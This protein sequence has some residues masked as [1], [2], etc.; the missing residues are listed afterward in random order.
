MSDLAELGVRVMRFGVQETTKELSELEQQAKKTETATEKLEE[1]TGEVAPTMEDAAQ[2]A[3]LFGSA[4][5]GITGSLDAQ[6]IALGVGAAAFAAF[7]AVAERGLRASA[8]YEIAGAALAQSLEHVG[9]RTGFTIGQLQDFAGEI[10]RATGIAED[11]TLKMMATLNRVGSMTGEEFKKATQLALD[12]AAALGG[13]PVNAAETLARALNQPA[14]G[15]TLLRRQFPELNALTLDHARALAESGQ[16]AKA[17]ALIMD[18]LQ[19]KIGGASGAQQGTLTGAWLASTDATDDFSRTLVDSTGVTDLAKGAL[20]LYTNVLDGATIVVKELT[21]T[22]G[23][24]FSAIGGL[25]GEI[26]ELT[27]VTRALTLAWDALKF[28][29]SGAWMVIKEGV[30]A[31]TDLATAMTFGEGSGEAWRRMALR[32]A[33]AAGVLTGNLAMAA[34]AQRELNEAQNAANGEAERIEKVKN[35]IRG[36][37]DALS[38]VWER[39]RNIGNVVQE[40][41]AKTRQE[42]EVLRMGSEARRIWQAGERAFEQERKK[43]IDA[44]GQWGE[45]E[46]AAANNARKHAEDLARLTI[47]VSKNEQ[48]QRRRG[49]AGDRFEQAQARAMLS[50]REYMDALKLEADAVNESSQ[51]HEIKA[52]IMRAENMLID[53]QGRKLG[54][55]TDA[56]REEIKASIERKNVGRAQG[57]V[58]AY[59]RSLEQEISLIRVDTSEREE[60]AAVMRAQ[61]LLYDEQGNKIAELDPKIEEHIRQLVREGKEIRANEQAIQDAASAFS[62]F[63]DDVISD[64]DNAIEALIR[65]LAKLIEIQLQMELMGNSGGGGLFGGIFESIFGSGGAAG[66]GAGEFFDAGTAVGGFAMKGEILHAARGRRLQRPQ[67]H[68]TRAGDLMTGEQD[69]EAV[70]PLSRDAQGNLGLRGGGSGKTVVQIFDQRKGGE[71]AKTEESNDANGDRMIRVYIRDEVNRAMSDGS[72]DRSFSK[73]FGLS[74][75]PTRRS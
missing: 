40:T 11:R 47:E 66:G 19:A 51:E 54:E 17:V 4:L 14:Q 34:R 61:N 24:M 48:A 42:V 53:A 62:S 6:T 25:I 72:M 63:V 3:G 5:E 23:P 44:T 27:G 58:A 50:V 71:K 1:Q 49:Q 38:T 67:M 37:G 74:R 33:V 9:N 68:N 26:V 59:V 13:D 69:E 46:K 57:E 15:I 39:Y 60:L 52:A 20:E 56:M 36:W 18:E 21:E 45:A 32:A 10:E 7:V 16:K 64:S 65:L 55:L 12:M 75:S 8:E 35:V 70:F 43:L 2:S 73:N 29:A 41:N 31:I 28:A 22:F 30:K